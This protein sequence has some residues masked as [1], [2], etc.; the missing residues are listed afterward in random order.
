MK[1]IKRERPLR[2]LNK[3]VSGFL[4]VIHKIRLFFVNIWHAIRKAPKKVE[5]I[6]RKEEKIEFPRIPPKPREIPSQITFPEKPKPK[7]I[8]SKPQPE[9]IPKPPV[10]QPQPQEK[11]Q[12]PKKPEQ[13][14]Q[15]KPEE[16]QDAQDIIED[17]VRKERENS[18]NKI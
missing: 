2:I 17:I 10:I 15:E 18:N 12:E 14:Q 7:P 4:K 9:I 5:E 1:K 3:I 13:A 8:I 11:P 16:I 6:E